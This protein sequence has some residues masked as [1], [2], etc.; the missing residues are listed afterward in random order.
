MNTISKILAAYIAEELS[1]YVE[2]LGT[3][4]A[5]QFRGW[6]K[7]SIMDALH[8][9]VNCIKGAWCTGKVL[10]ILYLDVKSAFPSVVLNILFHNMHI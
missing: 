4:P 7:Q 1:F 9:L 6:L 5:L 8:L 2:R 10:S 3:L